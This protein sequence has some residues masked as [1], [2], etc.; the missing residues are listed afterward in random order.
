MKKIY[1]LLSFL[2]AFFLLSACSD[3]TEQCLYSPKVFDT[4]NLLSN[5]VKEEFLN[6]DYPAGIVPVLFAADS[7]EPIK[8]GAYADECFDALVDSISE[9]KDFKRRGMLVLV[10]RNPEL[11]QI[12]L[13]S[14]YRVYCNMTGATSGVDYLNLQKQIREKGIEETLPLFLQNTSVRIQELNALP[15]YKKYRINS[16]VSAISTCLEYIGTPSENFYGKCVLTPIL[17]TTSLGYYVFKSW[18]LTFMFVCLIMLL[19][20]WALF[21]VVK[22]LLQKHVIGLIWSQKIINWGLRLLF[23]ISAAASAIILSSGRME[24]AIALQAIGVPFIENFQIAAADYVLKTS[25]VAAFFFVLMYALKRNI[26]SDIFLYS[27][28]EP[29]KQQ[30][31][32]HNLSDAQKTTLVIGH[33]ADLSKVEESSEPYSE[34]FTSRVSQRETMTIVSLAMAALFLI[35][36]PLIIMGIALTIYPLAGQCVKI[37]HVVSNNTLPEQIKKDRRTSLITNLLII[38][39]IAFITVLMGLFFNPM[40]DKKEIDLNEARTE[41]VTSDRLEG[42]YTVSKSIAGQV[43][44]SSGIIK[45][46]KNGAF[47]L[48]ITGKSSPKVYKLGFDSDEMIFVSE[49]L[50]NG[51]IHYDKDLDK[52]KVVFT[53]NE[54]TTWTIS[55]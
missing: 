52:I 3:D 11:I 38:F 36:R 8:M 48:L 26:V 17:K 42:N 32:Y 28:L 27:L 39:I 7:I 18:L 29:E 43:Q 6:F 35:P 31:I 24:D 45:K 25:F 53:I 34:L 21:L 16:A 37:Y 49:E 46:I 1:L 40:P 55:K 33:E 47:Q 22:R 10:S 4:G 13:G 9:S 44:V 15:S 50:G 14:R 41:L 54:H 51:I 20:R 23:S 2:S 5:K 12:R 30:A 19:C